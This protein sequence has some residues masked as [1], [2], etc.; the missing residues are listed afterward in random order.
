MVSRHQFGV[1]LPASWHRKG[2]AT[3]FTLGYCRQFLNFSWFSG[4]MEIAMK[5]C[6]LVVGQERGNFNRW[7]FNALCLEVSSRSTCE[8]LEKQISWGKAFAYWIGFQPLKYSVTCN[9]MPLCKC[10]LCPPQP[11]LDKTCSTAVLSI[12]LQ[13]PL[14]PFCPSLPFALSSG[15]IGFDPRLLKLW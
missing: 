10:G 12:Q 9:Q 8:E 15:H 13:H 2:I 4:C 7:L 11:H 5:H 3:R 14:P 1:H 6:W